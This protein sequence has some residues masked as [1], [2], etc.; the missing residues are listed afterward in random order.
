MLTSETT[1]ADDIAAPHERLTEI[2]VRVEQ[3]PAIIDA[4]TKLLEAAR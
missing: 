3:A 4:L 1:I 2:S